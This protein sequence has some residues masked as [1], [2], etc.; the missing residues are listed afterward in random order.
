MCIDSVVN[1]V[2]VFPRNH[3]IFF[4]KTRFI[5]LQLTGTVVHSVEFNNHNFNYCAVKIRS[6]DRTDVVFVCVS[7]I[8]CA[9]G[10]MEVE[11]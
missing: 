2:T 9:A 11:T 1:V 3:C 10:L 4:V 5:T 6:S 8:R 7:N